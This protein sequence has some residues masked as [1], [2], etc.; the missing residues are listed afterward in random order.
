MR[1]RLRRA[2]GV[3]RWMS[4]GAEPMRDEGGRI[5][6]WYGLCHDIDDQVRAEEALRS[7]KQQLE[8]M[9]DAVPVNILSFSP[10]GKIT[11]ASKRYLEQVGSPMVHIQDFDALARDLAHPEDFPAMFKN[12]SDG[13]ATGR[14]FVNRFRRRC[15]DGVYRWIEARAQP[16]RDADGTIVQWYIASIDIEDE[17]HAQEALRE[18]ERALRQLVETLPAMLDCATPDGEPIYRSLTCRSRPS[19]MW[20]STATSF[21]GYRAPGSTDRLLG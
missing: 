19:A 18:R 7:S 11:Y 1:Y 3:Y 10:S 9:I 6:Q 13:F 14:A 8:Q 15:K 21:D 16:L 12:A 20:R 2:D 4:S 17:M 5:V